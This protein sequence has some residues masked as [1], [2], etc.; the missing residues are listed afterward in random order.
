MDEGRVKKAARL[1]ADARDNRTQL[2]ALPDDLR[3]T[4]ETDAYQIQDALVEMIDDTTFG[5]KV[6]ATNELAQQGFGLD[7]PFSGR[8]LA[9]RAEKSPARLE[10]GDFSMFAIE[11]EVAFAISRD[12]PAGD[13]RYELDEVAQAAGAVHAAIEIVDSRFKDFRAVGG[14]SVIA[15]N[16][17]DG[18]FVYGKAVKGWRTM[19]LEDHTVSLIVNGGRVSQGNGAAA[20]G[21][22]V[23]SLHWLVN[24]VTKRGI[25]IRKGELITTGSW[26]GIYMAK[27]GDAV[28]ADFGEIGRIELR[29]EA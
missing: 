1:L 29:I 22:P 19:E 7:N 21:S 2:D 5:W 14:L 16:G 26:T 15:D 10:A 13:G 4:S 8:L 9:S 24:H 12:L 27:P 17:V 23:N 6:G 20:L 28:C 18:G 11:C 25:D 3:P